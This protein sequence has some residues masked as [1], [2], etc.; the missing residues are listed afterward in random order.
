MINA[1]F[2]T[3]RFVA[4]ADLSHP[5]RHTPYPHG[6]RMLETRLR[7]LAVREQN[8]ALKE[9]VDGRTRELEA[10]RLE[11]LERLAIAAEYRD[12]STSRH[13]LRVG[14]MSARLGAALGMRDDEVRVLRRAAALHDIGKV[15]IPDALLLKPGG[16]SADEMRIMRAHTTIG[17]HILGGSAAPL[18]KMAESIALSHHE[19]WDGAG[20][21]NGIGG[22]AIPLAGRIV[23]VADAF[24]ALTSDRPYRRARPVS[25]AVAEIARHRNSQFDGR[26]VGALATVV[27][28]ASTSRA[29]ARHPLDMDPIHDRH[30][31]LRAGGELSRRWEPPIFVRPK[32]VVRAPA[33]VTFQ[34]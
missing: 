22:E 20:Y 24:D 10:A 32:Q 34:R 12:G 8:R 14:E 33:R 2:D 4:A 31:V 6:F 3:T 17:A 30:V 13:T 19:R 27:D 28:R 25:D 26:V 7:Y 21:P 5:N 16:L 15:G 23:A 1:T 18:L 11:V 9:A 29:P